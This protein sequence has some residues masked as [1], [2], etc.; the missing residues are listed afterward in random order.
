MQHLGTLGLRYVHV[1]VRHPLAVGGEEPAE[2]G[3]VLDRVDDVD[4]Q[5]VGHQRATHRPTPRTDQH[6][7]FGGTGPDVLA[8][9]AGSVR[10]G[11]VADHVEVARELLVRDE[12]EFFFHPA[13]VALLVESSVDDMLLES[14]LA[15]VDQR[16]QIVALRC[17]HAGHGESGPDGGM[18]GLGD[19]E[20]VLDGLADHVDVDAVLAHPVDEFV[21]AHQVVSLLS[22]RLQGR[23]QLV[24]VLAGVER[25]H[26]FLVV[27]VGGFSVVGVVDHHHLN[28]HLGGE[29]D[30]GLV[31]RRHVGVEPV[32]VG[33]P[34]VGRVVLAGH[35]GKLAVLP[36]MQFAVE[37]ITVDVEQ[38]AQDQ[39]GLILPP[40]DHRL[41][42]LGH[43]AAV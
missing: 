37:A 28:A 36:G 1:N 34:V 42:E 43:H 9:R 17:P 6:R 11:V 22:H 3:A 39:P 14:G 16:D 35:D 7:V 13:V 12:R 19:G 29:S 18:A 41:C 10:P 23:A 31:D 25:P 15:G 40:V 30:L 5:Q 24:G 27:P 2:Q 21:L 26:Q 8:P 38:A 33:H 32:H 20:A 4:A